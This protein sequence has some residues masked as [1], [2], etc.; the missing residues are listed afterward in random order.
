MHR[1][2]IFHGML[3]FRLRTRMEILFRIAIE[4]RPATGGAKV[5]ALSLIG[6]FRGRVLG[7]HTHA[8]YRIQR[9]SAVLNNWKHSQLIPEYLWRLP[10]AYARGSERVLPNRDREGVG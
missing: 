8:A 9:P 7:I 5:I 4:L 6:R 2:R 1:T 3:R 10:V